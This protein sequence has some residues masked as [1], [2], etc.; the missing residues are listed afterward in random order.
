MNWCHSDAKVIVQQNLPPSRCG[1][2]EV[3]H[4]TGEEDEKLHLS[5]VLPRTQTFT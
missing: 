2:G 3:L 4:K 5:Q 1:D